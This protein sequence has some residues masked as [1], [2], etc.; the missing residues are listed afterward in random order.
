MQDNL[1]LHQLNGEGN[2]HWVGAEGAKNIESRI[3][4]EIIGGIYSEE[5]ADVEPYR[6]MIALFRPQRELGPR[7]VM[8]PGD[9]P[10]DKSRP[11]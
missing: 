3:S 11:C 4:P 8:N 9:R 7:F 2:A 10:Q 5:G 1:K 6:L